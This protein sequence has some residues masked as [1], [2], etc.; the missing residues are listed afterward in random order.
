MER[1]RVVITGSGAITPLGN[2]SKELWRKICLGISGIDK[3]KKFDVSAFPTQIAGEVKNFNPLEYKT[4]DKK[5]VKRMGLFLQY[6]LAAS[7]LAVKNSGLDLNVVDKHRIGTIIGAGMGD[8]E[9]V[10][11][12]EKNLEQKGVKGVSATFVPTSIPNMAA[13]SV[14]IKFGFKGPSMGIESACATGTHSVGEAFRKIQYN[15]A[16]VMICGGTEGTLFPLGFSGFCAVRALSTRNDE[17]QK[18]SR[19]FDLNRDGFVMSEGAGIV[20]LE[21]LNYARKRNARIYAELIGYGTSCDAFHIA[22]PDSNGVGAI[23]A[24]E[25]AIKD[26]NISPDKIDYINAHGTSTPMNDKVETIAIKSVLKN[27]AY[28][29]AVSSTKSMT[30]HLINATGTVEVI[31]CAMALFDGI[32]PPTINYEIPDPE[33]DLDYVPNKARDKKLN[34]VM[35]NS[36]GFGGQNAVLILK[37][38]P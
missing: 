7:E 25:R 17:P 3:I 12:E 13:A 5:D 22:A 8:L 14:S 29:V 27:H 19:P 24:I 2:S 10:V 35:T 33:C 18:A 32:I 4:I 34:I 36:F 6:A 31:I 28:K 37:R 38:Y 20:I 9:K 23:L 26:A 16:D 30:G 15:E 11:I 21:E 1:R